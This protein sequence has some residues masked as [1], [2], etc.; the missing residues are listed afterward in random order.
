MGALSFPSVGFYL[1]PP[2]LSAARSP[3][4]EK[5]FQETT[6]NPGDAKL[7]KAA[8]EFE[9]ILIQTLWRSMKESF[10]SSS[11]E[12][13][14]P[15][16]RTLEDLSMQAMSTALAASGGLGI[17][18]MLIHAMEPAMDT[19]QSGAGGDGGG[20]NTPNIG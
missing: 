16:H 3:A 13:Q 4:A 9:A 12:E 10:A 2:G 6:E 8:Q 1:G 20:S 18:R 17:A 5:P 15:A 14:D 19:T 11:E 7:R